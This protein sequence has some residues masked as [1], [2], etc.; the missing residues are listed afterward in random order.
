MKTKQQIGIT[1]LYREIQQR[2]IEC[3]EAWPD[4]GHDPMS[5]DL[6]DAI[7]LL[8]RDD[9]SVIIVEK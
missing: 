3:G 4:Y 2:L 9:V 8:D 1:K 5:D 7:R 6:I